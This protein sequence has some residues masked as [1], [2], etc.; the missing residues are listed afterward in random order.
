MRLQERVNGKRRTWF[1]KRVLCL[2]FKITRSTLTMDFMRLGRVASQMRNAECGMIQMR[3]AECGMIQMRN[4]ECGMIQ[5]R[6][7]ESE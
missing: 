3:N 7:T 1:Q 6:N 5:M 4:A 2:Y